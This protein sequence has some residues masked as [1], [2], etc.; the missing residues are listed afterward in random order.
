VDRRRRLDASFFD[1][2]I[3]DGECWLWTGRVQSPSRVSPGGYGTL[4]RFGRVIY[5]H[6]Y[7]YALINGPIPA[8]LEI[9]HS[10]DRPLCINP[11]HLSVGTHAD[12]MADAARKGHLGRS[13]TSA[14]VQ[15]IRAVYAGGG[16][17]QR[18]LAERY[19]LAQATLWAILNRR[20]YRDAAA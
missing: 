16:V 3:P 10:C 9:L 17:S 19:G 7:A 1:R 6:R 2:T 5:A 18:R 13:L 12:N 8:D 14:Q 11:A 15:N 4:S 20:S